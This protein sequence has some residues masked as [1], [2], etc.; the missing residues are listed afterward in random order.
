MAWQRVRE[1]RLLSRVLQAWRAVRVRARRRQAAAEVLRMRTERDV[2]G[3]SLRAWASGIVLQAKRRRTH[4]QVSS[5]SSSTDRQAGRQAGREG[6]QAMRRLLMVMCDGRC[7]SQAEHVLMEADVCREEGRARQA[8]EARA[9]VLLEIQGLQ[10][11]QAG[12][13]G[14]P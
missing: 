7:V 9:R 5:S 10:V 13:H 3:R 8:S 2:L 14:P 11:R 12:R 1:R 6:P 4:M